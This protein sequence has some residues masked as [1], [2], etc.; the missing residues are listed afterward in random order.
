MMDQSKQIQSYLKSHGLQTDSRVLLEA[1]LP[2]PATLTARAQAF[3]ARILTQVDQDAAKLPPGQTWLAT[4]DIIESVFGKYKTFTERGPLKDI[5]KLV[6]AIP[7]FIVDLTAPLVRQ[8]MESVRTIDVEAWAD[9]HLGVS[10]L[11]KRRRALISPVA[12]T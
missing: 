11:A 7:A 2:P 1:V 8:A 5:G 10:M 9:Q 4:S 6:L 3:T 12:Q